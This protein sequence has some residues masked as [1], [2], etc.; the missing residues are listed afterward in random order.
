[1]IRAAGKPGRVELVADGNQTVLLRDNEMSFLLGEKV[2]KITRKGFFGPKYQLWFGNDLASSLTSTDS[3]LQPVFSSLL[4]AGLDIEGH[5]TYGKEVRPLS[6]RQTSW[7][8]LAH[9]SESIPGDP[10][11]SA[12]RT[13]PGTTSISPVGDFVELARK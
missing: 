9:S 11:R 3:L 12:G 6:G 4:S 2:F 1:M 10:N 7:Q 13:S 8:H 5:W